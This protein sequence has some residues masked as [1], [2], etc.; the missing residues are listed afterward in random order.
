MANNPTKAGNFKEADAVQS[1][2]WSLRCLSH[3]KNVLTFELGNIKT[4]RVHKLIFSGAGTDDISEPSHWTAGLYQSTFQ[5]RFPASFE[6]F[7]GALSILTPGGNASDFYHLLR[8]GLLATININQMHG[9]GF[10]KWYLYGSCRVEYGSGEPKSK[11]QGYVHSD[12][13][14]SFSHH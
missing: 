3:Q 2:E 12:F 13:T 9:N 11:P 14:L 4:N 8:I 6:N 7:D 1:T 10:G 5:T